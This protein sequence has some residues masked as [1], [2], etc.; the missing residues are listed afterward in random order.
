MYFPYLRGRQYELIA[1]R[2]LIENNRLSNNIVP[3][4]EPVKVTPTL[5]NTIKAFN[6]NDK[7]FVFIRNPSVGTFVMDSNKP[8]NAEIFENIQ[9]AINSKNVYSGIIINQQSS[10]FVNTLLG[11]GVPY[12]QMT[13]LC[14]NSDEIDNLQSAF[15]E[16]APKYNVIPYSPAFR[17]VR[18]GDRIMIDDKFNKLPRNS[19]YLDFDDEFFSDDHLYCYED[20]YKGF[21]DYSIVG[22]DYSDSGFAP[23]AVAI[24]IVYPVSESDK[25]LRIH[26][27]VSDSN[28]DISDPA[29]K[30]Y[31]AL[32]KLVEWNKEK[33]LNTLAMQ[34]FEA[35]YEN[36]T[37]PGLGVVK[38][39]S[40]MHHIELVGRY[41]DEVLG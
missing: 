29:N 31:E 20:G 35:M 33:K 26:H 24:H 28:Y 21:S 5:L 10:E 3:I 23:Y 39:L 22:K 1:L 18:K 13:A 30:F 32:K 41:L 2:E 7:K 11:K 36:E 4:I 27:F 19:D 12:E 16:A 34:T 14:L 15:R 17:R 25:S 8:K 37:Y 6:D 9:N 40:I 38:K